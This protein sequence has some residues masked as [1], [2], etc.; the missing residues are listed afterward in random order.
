[1][2]LRK[3][4]EFFIEQAK[5]VHGDKY[6]Y[7]LIDYK[8][9]GTKINIICKIHGEFSQQPRHHL[10]GSGCPVCYGTKLYNN[11]EFISKAKKIHGD[12]YDY[13]NT[14]YNGAHTKIKIKCKKHD[15]IFEQK[16]NNHLSLKQGCPIC[17]GTKKKSLY[18]FIDDAKKIH[19]DKYDYTP[20]EYKNSKTKIKIICKK[21]GLFEQTPNC[22]L[23]GSGCPTCKSSIGEISVE[24][25]LIKN[26]IK[27]IKQH[28][29]KNCRNI[30]PLKFD[31]YLIEHN[32]C[33]EFDGVYHFKPH[34]S[35]NN[36]SNL[37]KSI[38]RDMIK[39]RYCEENNIKLIRINYKDN[40]EEKLNNIW[41]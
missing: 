17:S 16:P 6:D 13:S 27:Y 15:F 41:N 32:I 35:D 19:G 22:H 8:S 37:K 29:F 21:H 25:F 9:N 33:I 5:K 7:S 12:K 24:N 14:Q 3:T 18:E 38:E 4:K 40:V 10:H 34:W 28:W 39:N 20:V 26:N 30:L 11:E 2:S 36:S 31:F 23:H 1:M